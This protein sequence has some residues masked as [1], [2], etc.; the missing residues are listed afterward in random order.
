[1]IDGVELAYC[2]AT[3]D[4][5]LL[6]FKP[7]MGDETVPDGDDVVV[8]V[9]SAAY[10]LHTDTPWCLQS[11]HGTLVIERR[12]NSHYR[13]TQIVGDRALFVLFDESDFRT[14]LRSAGIK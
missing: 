2:T 6:R 7:R 13:L 5:D 8:D 11:R 12:G 4:G 9:T 1:M 10:V 14:A 3:H